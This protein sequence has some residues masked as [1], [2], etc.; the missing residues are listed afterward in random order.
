MG[1]TLT[2]AT[3]GIS[4]SDGL[5]GVSYS[6]Q[7]IRVDGATETDISGATSSTYT[8]ATADSGKTIKVKVSF[9]DEAG[10]DEELT[11]TA[12]GTV[13]AAAPACTAG[14]VWCATL[15]VGEGTRTTPAAKSLGYCSGI[16]NT[17][18]TAYGSLSDTTITLGGTT[19]T[20]RSVRWGGPTSTG[21]NFHLTLDSDFPSSG[22]SLLTLNVDSNS[23]GLSSATRGNNRGTV[24][25]NYQWATIP[26]G[27][28]SYAAGRQV[29]VELLAA[30][31]SIS[32]SGGDAVTEG[33]AAEF[34][35][36]LS[37]AAPFSAMLTIER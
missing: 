9:Q 1:Q 10:N 13:L 22:L 37:S 24:T 27:I 15:T 5:S 19:Y 3:D 25:N 11:S 34:T 35:V 20:V 18:T 29:T 16:T 32:I 7:W 2:A 17:C 4:D 30:D 6:Y 12:T 28:Q 31:P 26:A 21:D 33:T 23:L 14:N 36:T 8:L